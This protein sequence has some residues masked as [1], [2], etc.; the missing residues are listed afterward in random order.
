MKLNPSTSY[1]HLPT[2]PRTLP[3]FS[4]CTHNNR[5]PVGLLHLRRRTLTLRAVKAALRPPNLAV[6]FSPFF[7]ITFLLLFHLFT[8]LTTNG[9]IPNEPHRIWIKKVNEGDSI[10]F[11]VWFK[12]ANKLVF[13]QQG[14]KILDVLEFRSNEARNF[15]LKEW[16]SF[17]MVRFCNDKGMLIM[18][19]LDRESFTEF[20]CEGI[21]V[22]L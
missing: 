2:A 6:F 12:E 15:S 5:Q 4:R 16:N 20:K 18:W 22:V 10:S 21:E 14:G 8:P 7:G 11:R 17:P 1:T 9:Q 3:S 19:L 13:K